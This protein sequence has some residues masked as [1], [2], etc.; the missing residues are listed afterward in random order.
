MPLGPIVSDHTH[1]QDHIT[2]SVGAAY[3]ASLGGADIINSV[4]REEH[5][6]GIPTVRA[7]LEAIDAANAV[8]QIVNDSRFPSL[9]IFVRATSAII[10][11]WA[12]RKKSAVPDVT[13]NVLSSGTNKIKPN[14]HLPKSTSSN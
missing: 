9:P 4:T 14:Y 7:I 2:S 12:Y 11:A 5:T 8:I 1:G 10:I 13:R 3:L 6:G